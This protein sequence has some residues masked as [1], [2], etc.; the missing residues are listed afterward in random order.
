MVKC[1]KMLLWQPEMGD[2]FAPRSL[3]CLLYG[4][5]C[6]ALPMC[7]ARGNRAQGHCVAYARLA[8]AGAIATA[9]GRQAPK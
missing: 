9:S 2:Q 1:P 5:V 7:I 8:K 4:E 3:V 6:E